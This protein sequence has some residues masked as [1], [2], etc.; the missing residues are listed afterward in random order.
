MHKS[1]S[2]FVCS[3]RGQLSIWSRVARARVDVAPKVCS[4]AAWTATAS[5][6]R[7]HRMQARATY[8]QELKLIECQDHR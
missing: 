5:F 3:K 8:L 7:S 4:S 1:L 2:S 6:L